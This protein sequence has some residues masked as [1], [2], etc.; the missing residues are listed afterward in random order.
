VADDENIPS[1]WHLDKRVPVSIILVLL[2]QFTGGVWI[3]ATM[4]GDIAHNRQEIA[5]VESTTRRDIARIENAMESMARASQQQAV[6]LGRIEENIG[7]MRG[8]MQRILNVLEN[9]GPGLQSEGE[10]K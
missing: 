3:A 7:A 6:Q 2:F 4:N 5:R 8:D 1:G 9:R 10:W